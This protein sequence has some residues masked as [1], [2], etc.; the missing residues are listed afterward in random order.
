M[1]LS[2]IHFAFLSLI[3]ITNSYDL[4]NIARTP[5][6]DRT[7]AFYIC[8]YNDLSPFADRN[9]NQLLSIG[10]TAYANF[11]AFVD[12]RKP[13]QTK[14]A[15][16]YHIEKNNLKLLAEFPNVS[17]GD[18]NTLLNFCRFAIEKFPANKYDLILWNHGTGAIE[19]NIKKAINTSLLFKF[20]NATKLIEL[21]RSIEFL[22]YVYNMGNATD[23][24]GS[25]FDDG[26]SMY[27]KNQ[28]LGQV[29]DT[30]CRESLHGGQFEFI[31]F[32][33]CLMA[34]VEVLCPIKNANNRKGA[35]KYFIGSQ[36][37]VLGS[38]Y[39]YSR[40]LSPLISQPL[41]T[42]DFARHIVT[43]YS[44]TYHHLTRDYTQSAINLDQFDLLEKNINDI[45]QLLIHGLKNQKNRS[46]KKTIS[47]AISKYLC[48]HFDESTYK[49]YNSVLINIRNNISKMELNNQRETNQFRNQ[50]TDLINQGCDIIS[51]IV[52]IN[53]AGD[54]LKNAKGISIYFPENRIHPSYPSTDFAKLNSWSS[55]IAHFMAS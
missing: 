46:V 12:I 42:E 7:L 51:R 28:Q 18:A 19:P 22:E 17:S 36:E 38:G 52:L 37:V 47:Y 8:A 14:V 50:L 25:C 9:L 1:K 24:R 40:L 15:K 54:N 53:V 21:D 55:F 4:K 41:A 34:M 35:A 48:T 33:A 45:A 43:S 26:A 2:I 6:K 3:F 10:S 16:I 44:K 31:I 20:N 11:V 27:I 49:D 13:N 29:L 39:D 23:E 5:H 32:D 30:I